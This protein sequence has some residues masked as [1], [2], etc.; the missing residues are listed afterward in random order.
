MTLRV[1]LART[2]RADY[3][4][5]LVAAG[6]EGR[7]GAFADSAIYLLAPTGVD[8]LP[9]FTEG[10]VSVQDEASQLAARVV[11]PAPGEKILDACAAPGGKTCHILEASLDIAP[12]I[13]LTAVDADS[14]RLQQLT[15]NL[16][17]LSLQCGVEVA[18][19]LD[20]QGPRSAFDKILI[21]AP[22]S[23]TGVIRRHPDIKLLRRKSDIAKLATTQL[24]LLRAVWGLLKGGG[25]LVYSTC[26]VLMAEND[27]VIGEFVGG[28]NDVQ[29]NLIEADWGHATRYGRQLLPTSRAHDGF[30]FAR[31]MKHPS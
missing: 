2:S 18:D 27:D 29:V 12:G 26:S 17:R 24:A 31:L 20:W 30:Y 14:T 10:L 5:Q 28:R 9:G 7:A 23:A 6:L 25:V 21:D 4:E 8:K 11:S 13:E 22:C 1:N 19:L 15:D 3:L 16:E